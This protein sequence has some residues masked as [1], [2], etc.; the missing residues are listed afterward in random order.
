MKR[1]TMKRSRVLL[2]TLT[3]A[4]T[5]ATVAGCSAIDTGTASSTSAADC[6]PSTS[7]ELY[8][9]YP[10]T[11]LSVYGDLQRFAESAAKERGYTVSYT[12]DDDDLQKQNT[13]VQ[14]LV[15]QK[16]PA[17][18]SYPLEPTSMEALAGEARSNCTVW[19]SY[20]AP[21]DN[22]DASILF[23]GTESGKALGTAAL[24]W[25]AKQD[26]PVKVLILQNRD[27][28]VG[29]ERDD[30]LNSVFP[31]DAS[32]IEVV[33]TQKAGDRAEGEQITREVLQA[34]PDLNMVLSYNDDSG[35]GAEQAFI[36]AG[37]D[38]KDPSI[39][40]GGQ[41]G[42]KEGL[43]AVAAGGLYKVSVAVRIKDIGE[44]V[45]NVPID[46][47]EGKENKGVNVPPVALTVDS[48]ELA[49]YLSDFS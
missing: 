5:L 1:V 22:Q 40:I 43:T 24:D 11:S 15:T 3:A 27:L 13:N 26:K 42:S 7:K 29:A 2:A 6:E 19:V 14:A 4:A 38:P 10:L 9:D 28:A 30:G 48:P 31:G 16:V 8:F 25:A 32:N 47:L 33:A 45:A 49:E 41:D 18:V 34:H 12:A 46:I 35:L 20:A 37:V 39:F 44:A 21:L 23:S 36:N 17:I